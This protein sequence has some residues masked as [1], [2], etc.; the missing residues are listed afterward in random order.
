MQPS[1]PDTDIETRWCLLKICEVLIK[2][3]EEPLPKIKLRMPVRLPSAATAK[4]GSPEVPLSVT[5]GQVKPKITIGGPD[6]TRK[7]SDTAATTPAIKLVLGK[8]GGSQ[9]KE[10]KAGMSMADLKVCQ[11]L[12]QKLL[13][14]KKADLFRRPVGQYTRG[15]FFWL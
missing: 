5:S 15:P 10:Q 9:L 2:P 12:M 4:A 3:S 6:L 1:A 14:T 8:K 7:E 11:N 13:A